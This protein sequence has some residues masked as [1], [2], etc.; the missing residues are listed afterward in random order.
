MKNYFIHIDNDCKQ[1]EIYSYHDLDS[2]HHASVGMAEIQSYIDPNSKVIAFLPSNMRGLG[3]KPPG[4]SLFI[5]TSYQ[6]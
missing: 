2:N 4:I 6:K 5:L 3:E 1:A